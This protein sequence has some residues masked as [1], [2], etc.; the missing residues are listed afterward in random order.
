MPIGIDLRPLQDPVSR[1]VSSYARPLIEEMMR[2]RGAENFRFFTAGRKPSAVLDG[3]SPQSK[4]LR[5]PSR[6]VNF[7]MRALGSPTLDGQ[8]G[9]ENIFM[10]NIG[11]WAAGPT[12]SLTVTVH[13]L[14]FLI[15]PTW[16]SWRARCWHRAINLTGLLKR[17]DRI[18]TL[19]EYVKGELT[20]LLDIDPANIHHIPPGIPPLQ[21]DEGRPFDFP[22]IL[23]LG[24]LEKRKN[25]DGALRAFELAAA[26]I[27]NTHF[28]L[29]GAGDCSSF[30]VNSSC[31]DRVHF[32]GP[33]TP[34]KKSALLRHATALFMPSFHEGFGFPP[35]EAMSVGVPVLAS[36]AGAL[37]ETV[38][39]AGLL[40][41]PA[42]VGGFAEMLA[43]ICL[44]EALR[45]QL[46]SRGLEHSRLF[47]WE[48][49]AK[50]T[51][52]LISTPLTAKN[53][54]E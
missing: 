28:V 1:G 33:V 26:R 46:A 52:E 54:L 23:F 45:A 31:S 37:P 6:A 42:D 5:L 13:D 7:G 15:D 11:F 53:M 21:A 39:D 51:W 4:H 43:E 18:V 47:S 25:I 34:G 12:A 48:H 50:A 8:T 3:A 9:A 40:L 10:P 38:G 36:T 22:Y 17:A 41:D 16:Y 32:L 30:M 35:L 24:V 27:P 49:C 20:D 29:A 14:S 44:N 2:Q 19:S